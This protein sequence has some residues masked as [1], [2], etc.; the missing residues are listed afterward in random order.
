VVDDVAFAQNLQGRLEHAMREA[1]SR[2][3]PA[4]NAA[5]PFVQRL[6]DRV[7]YVLMRALLLVNGKRY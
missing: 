1:G 4:E 3:D 5:R 2:V 7:A 6:L